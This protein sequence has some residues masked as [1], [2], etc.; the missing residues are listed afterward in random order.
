MEF[1]VAL[2]VEDISVAVI[3]RHQIWDED[4]EPPTLS[5][6]NKRETMWTEIMHP[7]TLFTCVISS[8][9]VWQCQCLNYMID[10]ILQSFEF[11]LWCNGN[12]GNRS[13]ASI[14]LIPVEPSVNILSRCWQHIYNLS[15][16]LPV[17]DWSKSNNSMFSLGYKAVHNCSIRIVILKTVEYST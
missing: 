5:S 2:D 14:G 6:C 15:I 17:L 8:W 13:P 12:E 3:T 16:K 9:T 10:Q 7:I 1:G 4:C 11:L